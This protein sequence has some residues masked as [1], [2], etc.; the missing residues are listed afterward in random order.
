[1]YIAVSGFTTETINNKKYVRILKRNI[2]PDLYSG[3]G[4]P[5]ECEK[6]YEKYTINHKSKDWL[7]VLDE[8]DN[9]VKFT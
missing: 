7:L 6:G 4:I 1:M 3:N 2:D 5:I 8:N 9:V